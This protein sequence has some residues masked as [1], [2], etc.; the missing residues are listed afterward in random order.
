MSD[1]RSVTLRDQL[2]AQ[3]R[4]T[5]KG[6]S[7]A[8]RDQWLKSAEGIVALGAATCAQLRRSIKLER[9]RV[10]SRVCSGTWGDNWFYTVAPTSVAI[11]DVRGMRLARAGVRWGE[12]SRPTRRWTP[13]ACVGMEDFL[14]EKTP[15]E[16][17]FYRHPPSPSAL[18][19]FYHVAYTKAAVRRLAD[20]GGRAGR[21]RSSQG[22]KARQG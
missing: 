10:Q 17:F 12:A 7:P 11:G 1:V 20:H 2:R 3:W 9:Q 13:A 14:D 8:K 16:A 15:D 21:A 5:V 6:F 19:I 4:E 22:K 18:A